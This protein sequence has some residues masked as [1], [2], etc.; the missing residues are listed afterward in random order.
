MFKLKYFVARND[1][2]ELKRKIQLLLGAKSNIHLV[3][4]LNV[5]ITLLKSNLFFK[6]FLLLFPQLSCLVS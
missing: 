3:R 1:S 2:P 6:P 4:L 5:F